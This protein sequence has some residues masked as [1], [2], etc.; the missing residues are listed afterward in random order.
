[1][2]EKSTTGIPE[3][4]LRRDP[5]RNITQ[6][7][8]VDNPQRI[9]QVAV[10]IDSLEREISILEEAIVLQSGRFAVAMRSEPSSFK[11]EAVEKAQTVQ[12]ELAESIAQQASRVATLRG[13]VN[14]MI[15]RCEL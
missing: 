15:D 6:D 8:L 4:M 1:M 5:M 9:S 12:C 13:L 2:Q 11:N 3:Y 14:G 7:C 10:A